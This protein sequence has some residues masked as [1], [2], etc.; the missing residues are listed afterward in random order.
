MHHE[1]GEAAAAAN[2][3]AAG[4]IDGKARAKLIEEFLNDP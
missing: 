4:G 1:T 2:A 3:A